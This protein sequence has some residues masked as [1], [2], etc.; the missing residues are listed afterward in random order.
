MFSGRLIIQLV[1]TFLLCTA[2]GKKTAEP[3]L[4]IVC[5]TETLTV[6]TLSA[7]SPDT[8]ADKAALSRAAHVW[9]LSQ[10]VDLKP[11]SLAAADLAELIARETR[12]E[13]KAERSLSIYR[14][15]RGAKALAAQAAPP[16]AILDSLAAKLHET[17]LHPADTSD[18]LT[19][20]LSYIFPDTKVAAQVA[21]F[22]RSESTVAISAGDTKKLI[23]GLVGSGAK[24][25]PPA[26]R[27]N[28]PKPKITGNMK[29]LLKYRPET[30]IR[31]TM[32]RHLPYL[33]GLYRKEL[34]IEP[35]MSGTIWIAFT[36]APSGLVSDA[37]LSRSDIGRKE[38][39]SQVLAYARSIQFGSVPEKSGSMTFEFP[40]EFHPE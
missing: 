28:P 31:D 40:F 8:I 35:S 6:A 33:E 14:A 38:L 17:A 22:L 13:W 20:V 21:D 12:I 3:R 16:G 24:K 19:T 34:K 37:A 29:E 30:A 23:S 1:A 39:L 2:C 15:C 18:R 9:Q 4:Y 5:G 11:D 10:A 26:L 32:L 27:A 25:A 36:I 7:F